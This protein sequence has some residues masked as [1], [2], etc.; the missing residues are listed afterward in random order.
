M[1]L[2]IGNVVK[3]LQGKDKQNYFCVVGIEEP[4]VMLSDGK[5]RKL[6]NPKR[7]KIKHY[8]SINIFR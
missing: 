7:K 8:E 3:S 6:E 1:H 4:Y 2:E 5:I